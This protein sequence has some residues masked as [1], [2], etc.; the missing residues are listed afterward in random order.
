MP[1]RA[2]PQVAAK[3]A[4]AV[5]LANLSVPRT[6]IALIEAPSASV[7]TPVLKLPVAK[8]SPRP[9][10]STETIA[11]AA[12]LA[13]TTS[14][15]SSPTSASI[16]REVQLLETATQRL[17]EERKSSESFRSLRARLPATIDASN[18]AKAA[19]QSDIKAQVE[20]HFERVRNLED[21]VATHERNLENLRNNGRSFSSNAGSV[22]SL[23]SR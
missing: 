18:P 10:G 6:A 8:L 12:N 17:A 2:S 11:I 4:K 19:I 13:S 7:A 14:T 23:A 9:T 16:D 21:Q 3:S 20:R 15:I 22:N 1:V 5:P